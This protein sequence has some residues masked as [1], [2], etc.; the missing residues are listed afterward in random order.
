MI[1]NFLKKIYYKTSKTKPERKTLQKIDLFKEKYEKLIININNSL[2][3]KK[4]LNFLHSGPVGD[5]IY[6]L[7][8]IQKIS[9]T[10]K[11]NFLLM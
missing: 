2:V 11:C 3:E 10:H 5:L 7:A 4:E 9:K 1:K 8:I 6:S